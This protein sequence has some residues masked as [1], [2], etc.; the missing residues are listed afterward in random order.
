VMTMPVEW[1][2]HYLQECYPALDR[3]LLNVMLRAKAKLFM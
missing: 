2:R 1:R 3:S